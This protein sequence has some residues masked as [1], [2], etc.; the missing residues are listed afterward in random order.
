MQAHL[1]AF[2]GQVRQMAWTDHETRLSGSW[3]LKFLKLHGADRSVVWYFR[4]RQT[5]LEN[6]QRRT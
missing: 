1:V 5:A 3:T 4:Q 6:F 2:A